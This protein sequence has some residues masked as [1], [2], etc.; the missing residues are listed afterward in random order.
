MFGALQFVLDIGSNHGLYALYAATLGASVVVLEPQAHLCRL[1]LAAAEL[2][3]KVSAP[4][5]R[6]VGAAM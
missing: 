2:N 3:G 6:L 4:A 1:I 5:S